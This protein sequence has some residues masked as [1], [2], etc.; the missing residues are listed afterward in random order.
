YPQDLKYS[1]KLLA[2]GGFVKKGEQ[3]F[4]SSGHRVEFTLIT[5]SGNSQRD[6]TCIMIVNDFKKL[7]IKVNYQP[8]DFNIMIDKTS[9]SLDW[10][11]IVMALTG[12]KIEPYGGTNVWKS[13]GRMHMFDQRLPDPDGTTRVKGAGEGEFEMGRCCDGW[14]LTRDA[15]KRPQV[16]D[17]LQE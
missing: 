17:R 1:E 3:L 15:K 5:N 8:I 13:E 14:A 7:G 6:A 16:S 10:D 11:A 9:N 2:K 4:D 12:N